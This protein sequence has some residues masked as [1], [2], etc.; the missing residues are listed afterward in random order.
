M[1]F[2]QFQKTPISIASISTMDRCKNS[3]PSTH[4]EDHDK[5]YTDEVAVSS[6][7]KLYTIITTFISNTSFFVRS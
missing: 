1:K 7:F 6:I 3:I 2:L 5:S 4:D